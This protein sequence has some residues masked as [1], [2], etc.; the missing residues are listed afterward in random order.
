MVNSSFNSQKLIFILFF[1]TFL[2]FLFFVKFF[3]LNQESVFVYLAESFS[4][5]NLVNINDFFYVQ[6]NSIFFSLISF[7]INKITSIDNLVIMRF[8]SSLGFC[9]IIFLIQS[10]LIKEKLI[11]KSF[12]YTIL[13]FCPLFFIFSIRALPDIFAL[14]I[15][16]L[17]TYFFCYSKVNYKYFYSLFFISLSILLKIFNGYLLVFML[18]IKFKNNPIEVFKTKNIIFFISSLIPTII[19]NLWV[20]INFDFLLIDPNHISL[21]KSSIFD[22]FSIFYTYIFFFLIFGSLLYL[23]VIFEII[24]SLKFQIISIVIFAIAY[25]FQ[26]N[27][28]N[29]SGEL[30]FGFMDSYLRSDILFYV[31]LYLVILHFFIIKN[32]LD[33]IDLKLLIIILFYLA[34]LSLFRPSQRY[35]I[36]IFPFY[37]L[38]MNKLYYFSLF[39]NFL[40][41]FFTFTMALL[42]SLSAKATSDHNYKIE[43]F[44]FSNDRA[45]IEPGYLTPHFIFKDYYAHKGY[46]CEKIYKAYSYKIDNNAINIDS[47]IFFFKRDSYL[48]LV[49]D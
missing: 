35:L 15:G 45:C 29:F 12:I 32:N 14:G 27:F 48:Y 8:L 11:N 18:Y 38:L 33:K 13:F 46:K 42:F 6:A 21:V 34:I 47:K 22:F 43:S 23:K 36:L 9:M 5:F 28:L 10:I 30:S 37:I 39:L 3:T 19:Y 1:F 26:I 31:S 49:F 24:F 41:I 16:C 44:I 25:I 17:A 2:K 40:A 4:E 20:Y 7:F